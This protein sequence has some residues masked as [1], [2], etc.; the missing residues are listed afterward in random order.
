MIDFWLP[1]FE[2][3]S[4]GVIVT[5]QFTC[6]AIV[7][8]FLIGLLF[9]LMQLTRSFILNAIATAYLSIFRGTPMLVQLSIIY[10]G[11]PS[12]T[13]LDLSVFFAGSLALSLNSGAYVAEILR[14]GIQSIDKGQMEAARS[15]GVS[16]MY[17]MRDLILP[18]AF[19]NIFPALVN[20]GITLLK[21][22][23]LVSIIGAHE[24]MR[25]A[26]LVSAETYNYFTPLLMAAILY[27]VMVMCMSYFGKITEKKLGAYADH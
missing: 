15:L 7:G 13:P 14:S 10:F 17:M 12:V 11:I 16:Y 27:Y 9:A 5:L 1:H 20:E 21:D 24:I 19:R 18:Q 26:Q 4:Q 22:T 2:F 23:A 3:I 25:N 6:T 8:G